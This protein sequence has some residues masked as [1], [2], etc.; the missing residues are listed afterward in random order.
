MTDFWELYDKFCEYV[1][2]SEKLL[3]VVAPITTWSI[4]ILEKLVTAQLLN[5]FLAISGLE[6]FIPCSQQP[7]TVSYQEVSFIQV[8]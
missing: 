8:L 5:K 6:M 4:V 1:S 2:L 7:T 3:F